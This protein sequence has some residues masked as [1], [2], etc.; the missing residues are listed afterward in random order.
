VNLN[1]NSNGPKSG[2]NEQNQSQRT[3]GESLAKDRSEL[4][5]SSSVRTVLWSEVVPPGRGNGLRPFVVT[6]ADVNTAVPASNW[7]EPRIEAE[8]IWFIKATGREDAISRIW[9]FLKP[10]LA[11]VDAFDVAEM[12]TLAC[13][14]EKLFLSEEQPVKIITPWCAEV[15]FAQWATP[16]VT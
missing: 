14:A 10:N 15:A 16:R 7:R 13:A 2:N 8:E 3:G 9:E 12:R 11:C 6:T 5:T 4:P 1:V